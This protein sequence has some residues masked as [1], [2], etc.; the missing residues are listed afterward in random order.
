MS[1]KQVRI[2][3]DLVEK[4]SKYSDLNEIIEEAFVAYDNRNV[5]SPDKSYVN[6]NKYNG[7][8]RSMPAY[9]NAENWEAS[10]VKWVNVHPDNQDFPTVMGTFVYTDPENGRPLA[11]INGTE[12]TKRRT[13][14]VAAVASEH[15][16]VE[17][18]TELGILGAGVQSYEQVNAISEVR[19]IE[20]IFVSDVDENAVSKFKEHFSK[21]Y[22]VESVTPNKLTECDILCT[23][24]P[25]E[26]PIID[27]IRNEDIH[28]NAMGADAPQ[29]QEIDGSVVSSNETNIVVD[30]YSQ[31][32]HSGEISKLVSNGKLDRNDIY[33]DLGD[34][35]NNN[36]IIKNTSTIFDSTGLAIQDVAT[37]YLVYSSVTEDECDELG[38][39]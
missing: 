11:V 14:S 22:T 27:E 1:K 15:M 17:S 2:S 7:D 33:T 37:A 18:A 16:S 32:M 6:I 31:A 36:H 20:T 13:A 39:F 10:G 38:I 29:K 8:F 3:G 35:V 30:G 24:T 9:V 4:N 25:V 21:E 23:T 5:D 28:I 34:I 12:I 26:D 19:D